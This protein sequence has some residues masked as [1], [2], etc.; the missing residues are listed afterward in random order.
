MANPED[1]LIPDAASGA[2]WLDVDNKF[3]RH[4]VDSINNL[5]AFKTS[6]ETQIAEA[7]TQIADAQTELVEANQLAI[8]NEQPH[9]VCGLPANKV[10][11]SGDVITTLA[12]DTVLTSKHVTVSDSGAVTIEKEGPWIITLVFSW[13][14]NAAHWAQ[15]GVFTHG[16]IYKNGTRIGSGMARRRAAADFF[17]TLGV[18]YQGPLNVGD[19]LTARAEFDWRNNPSMTIFKDAPPLPTGSQIPSGQTTGNYPYSPFG[20]PLS[21]KGVKI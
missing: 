4:T 8:D 17:G 9:F 10:L 12:T 19:V 16:Y 7:Q 11:T 20:P 3:I 15:E 2:A 1:F 21:F 6:V 13:L 18:M 14:M 5:N